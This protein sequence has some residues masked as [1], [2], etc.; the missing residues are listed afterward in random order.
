M[1]CL[2]MISVSGCA[3]TRKNECHW[4]KK[5]T[6]TAEDADKISIELGK[7]LKTH[8]EKIIALCK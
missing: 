3:T 4:V 2:I 5:I 1:L 8:N 7:Q 6:W